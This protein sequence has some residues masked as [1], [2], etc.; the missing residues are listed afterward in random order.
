[1][2]NVLVKVVGIAIGL[3]VLFVLL[4][5]TVMPFYNTAGSINQTVPY[6]SAEWNRSLTTYS[7]MSNGMYQGILLLV[8][9][10]AMIGVAMAFYKKK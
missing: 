2:N 5:A 1:M 9:I 10:L 8:F 7:G 4:N 3:T 6:N